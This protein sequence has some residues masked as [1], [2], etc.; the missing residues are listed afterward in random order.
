V[1]VVTSDKLSFIISVRNIFINTLMHGIC[2]N[3]FKEQKKGAELRELLA[4][5]SLSSIVT[6][7]QVV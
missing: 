1:F 2:R 5:E 4:L 3:M 7:I 6:K